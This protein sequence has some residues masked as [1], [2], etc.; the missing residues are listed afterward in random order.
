MGR[1]LGDDKDK[2][3]KRQKFPP[4]NLR[5]WAEFC[6]LFAVDP[7]FRSAPN[8]RKAYFEYRLGKIYSLPCY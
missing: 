8:K 2:R 7:V 4:K 1:R 5:E 6:W 3:M